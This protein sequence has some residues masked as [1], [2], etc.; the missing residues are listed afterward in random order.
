MTDIQNVFMIMINIS[1]IDLA[2]WSV[3]ITN[4][5]AI[6]TIHMLLKEKKFQQHSQD[7]SINKNETNKIIYQTCNYESC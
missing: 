4:L 1:Q 2:L 3:F 6:F 7:Q 5:T